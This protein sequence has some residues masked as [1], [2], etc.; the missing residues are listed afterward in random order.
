MNTNRFLRNSEM[1]PFKK[2]TAPLSSTSFLKM[3]TM[4]VNISSSESKDK[5]HYKESEQTLAECFTLV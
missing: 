1:L 4:T 3:L 5:K 2:N